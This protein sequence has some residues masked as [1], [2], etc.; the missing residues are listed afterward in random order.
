MLLD[1]GE[2]VCPQCGRGVF[3]RAV[4]SVQPATSTKVKAPEPPREPVCRP[5]PDVTCA[6]C[7]SSRVVPQA[8]TWVQGETGG[9]L[10]AYICSKPDALLFKGTAY[11]T[12]YARICA[13]CGYAE[14][15]AKGGAEHLYEAYCKSLEK[16][17]ET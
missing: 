13:Q 8:T 12:L 17:R 7:G 11:A 4:E 16:E 3:E 10:Q 14:L 2:S 6:K 9:A 1:G 15:Y 5:P